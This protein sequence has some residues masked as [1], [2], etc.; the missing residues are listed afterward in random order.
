MALLRNFRANTAAAVDPRWYETFFEDDWLELA[1]DHDV[2]QT[3]AEVDFL[4]ERLELEPG[5]RILDLACGHGR[6]AVELAAMGFRVTGLDIS[7]PSLAIARERAAERGVELELVRLDMSELRADSEFGAAFN[8]SSAF[9]YLPREQDDQEVLARVAR[10]LVPGGQFLIDTMNGQWL[11]R[12]FERRAG[13]KLASGTEITEER[14]YDPATK[15]S[16][17]TWTLARSDGSRSE[18][19]HSMRIYTCPELCGM[20]AKAGLQ[21]NG[22]WGAVDGSELSVDS[23]RLIV[24]GRR[25]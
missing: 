19:R 15:R 6:H 4:I 14:H 16:S 12:N 22:L 1:V 8:F 7:E 13:R 23:R 18:L 2:L 25:G 24:R 17:A 11:V 5:A 21:V 20:F 10:A 3:R 9:G